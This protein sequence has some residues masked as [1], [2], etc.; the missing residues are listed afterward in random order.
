[1]FAGMPEFQVSFKTGIAWPEAAIS[2]GPNDPAGTGHARLRATLG[3][4]RRPPPRRRDAL[5]T[6]RGAGLG[7]TASRSRPRP[8]QPDRHQ[9]LGRAL[10]RPPCGS[11]LP[12]ASCASGDMG[13][14][15]RQRVAH[16]RT[17][18][19]QAEKK[20][21]RV[22]VVSAPLSLVGPSCR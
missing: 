9:R 11:S 5:P 3:C 13:C 4:I 12:R 19:S 2:I 8:L 14:R 10:V 6:H 17:A 22:F 1:M 7:M 20:K 16:D 21:G 18:T 15:G